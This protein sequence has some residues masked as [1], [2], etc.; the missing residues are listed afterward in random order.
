MCWPATARI[1]DL[2][3]AGNEGHFATK[4]ANS[5]SI[6]ALFAAH[7]ADSL[8][9]SAESLIVRALSWAF[10]PSQDGFF[11]RRTKYTSRTYVR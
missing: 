10:N 8:D 1:A 5:G 6:A 7:F 2:I 11:V 4:L 3:I 9:F